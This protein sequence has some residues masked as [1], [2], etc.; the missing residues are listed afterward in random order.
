MEMELIRLKNENRKMK[1]R[2][3]KRKLQIHRRRSQVEEAV[4][5][6]VVSKTEKTDAPLK[7]DIG[8]S[9]Q[10]Q[11]LAKPLLLVTGGLVTQ[12]AKIV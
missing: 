4:F 8:D 3:R 5:N 12:L 9:L 10:P 6:Q 11:K 7:A 1:K 2:E